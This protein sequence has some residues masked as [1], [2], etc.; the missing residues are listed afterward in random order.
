MRSESNPRAL[1]QK[2]ETIKGEA[3]REFARFKA[4]SEAMTSTVIAPSTV[5]VLLLWAMRRGLL[6]KISGH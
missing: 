1:K 4:E 2:L 3:W 5:D 6:E